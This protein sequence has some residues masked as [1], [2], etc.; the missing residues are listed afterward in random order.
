MVF[1]LATGMQLPQGKTLTP[2][3]LQMLR[4]QQMQQQQQQQQQQA[5]SPQIK[6]VGKPQVQHQQLYTNGGGQVTQ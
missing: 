6:A 3:H 2:A 4:Q 5:T 1:Y